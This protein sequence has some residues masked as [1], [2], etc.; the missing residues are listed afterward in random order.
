MKLFWRILL[1]VSLLVNLWVL[2]NALS[3][4]SGRLG[5]LEREVRVRHFLSDSVLFVLPKGIDVR[6][7]SE[8]GIGAIGQFENQ[9]FTIVITSDD[10]SLVNYDVSRKDVQ[11]FGHMY[12]VKEW[13]A[14]GAAPSSD[15]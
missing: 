3:S 12:S 11:P 14:G 8:R 6:D 7:A 9:R 15:E 2:L 1:I 10:A 4:P 5:K 13:R